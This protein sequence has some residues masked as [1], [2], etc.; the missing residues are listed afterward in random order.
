MISG[1]C[2][3]AGNNLENYSSNFDYLET[4]HEHGCVFS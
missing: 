1:T 3:G 4:N 2:M